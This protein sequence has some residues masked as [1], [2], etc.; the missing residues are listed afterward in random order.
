M[1][2]LNFPHRVDD[3]VAVW[4]EFKYL[5]DKYNCLSLG[6]GA[7]A[8]NPPQF[9]QDELFKAIAEGNNQYTRTF[10]NPILTQKVAEIYG[11]GKLKRDINH[12]KEIIISC[13]AYN[14]IMSA[15]FAYVNPGVGEEV[16]AFEPGWP[17]YIDFV[18]FAGGVYKPLN[19]KL[20][21]G[22]WHFDA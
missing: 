10:G 13:G 8:A 9:L 16:L 14:V 3:N 7:P 19:L 11:K 6:E 4:A 15:I 20:R 21:D 2:N 12:L 18:Q 5:A 22:K 17:C 1:E